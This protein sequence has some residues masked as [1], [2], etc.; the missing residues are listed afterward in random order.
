MQ[1]R[2][3]VLAA[4]AAISVAGAVL[5][6]AAAHAASKPAPPVADTTQ[7]IDFHHGTSGGYLDSSPITFTATTFHSHVYGDS[8]P[9]TNVGRK[10]TFTVTS[11]TKHSGDLG[12]KFTATYSKAKGVYKGRYTCPGGY[13]DTFAVTT[14]GT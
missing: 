14:T 1:V 4:T 9:F 3:C 13:H 11:T 8:G 2:R 6:P 10:L 7:T 5:P 12:C